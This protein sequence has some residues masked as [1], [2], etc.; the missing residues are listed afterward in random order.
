MR[1]T[2]F[3]CAWECVLAVYTMVRCI[4]M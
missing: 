3:L 4:C 2:M 1:I